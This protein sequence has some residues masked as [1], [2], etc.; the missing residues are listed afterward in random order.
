MSTLGRD[1][2][3]DRTPEQRRRRRFKRLTYGAYWTGIVAMFA[4]FLLDRILAGAVLYLAGVVVGSAVF[5]YARFGTDVMLLDE[6]D[7]R[8]ERA[9]SHYA[10]MTVGYVGLAVFPVLFVLSAAGRFE[11]PPTLAGVLYA[12]SG[13]FLLWGAYYTWFR[14]RS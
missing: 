8:L 3:H 14:S 1:G 11:F 4:G 5:A 9:A 10:V 13:L 6:R 7:R 2:D 12:V